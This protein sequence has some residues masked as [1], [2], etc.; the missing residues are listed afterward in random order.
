ML[1]ISTII[2]TSGAIILPEFN[3][4]A[5]QLGG[6]GIRWYAVAYLVG[7]LA[8]WYLLRREAEHKRSPL[9][10]QTVDVLINYV[11]FGVII[12]GRLGYILFYNSGYYLAHPLAMLRIWE[13][14][15]AFH[16]ALLGIAIAVLIMAKRHH[17]P[18]FVLTDRI[19]LVVPIGLF[20]G[21][22]SNFIN[23]ELYGRVTALP[24]A[25]VFPISDGQPRH[26]SQL[27]EAGLE[28]LLLGV[29]MLI[30]WR[31]R[32]LQQHGR[33]TGVLLAG[34]GVARSMIEFVREPDAQIGL[35]LD[36]VSMGQLLSVPMIIFGVYLVKRK[37]ALI[38]RPLVKR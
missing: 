32:W 30:L 34:Y 31:R 20:F 27:Y 38:S 33:I 9:H 37:P 2:G 18:F 5:V 4:F 26:P 15:M 36:S 23:G 16:G 7:L 25:M 3:T 6:F 14:G 19:A 12:G 22:L 13:G 21:R 28:G 35:L 17:V 1:T 11:L 29:I 10:P 24:W 8:G